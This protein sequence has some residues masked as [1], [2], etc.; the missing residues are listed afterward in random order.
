MKDEDHPLASLTRFH[1]S[2][3][4]PHPSPY[5]TREFLNAKMPSEL[6]IQIQASSSH[7]PRP[8]EFSLPTSL[9]PT[10]PSGAVAAAL[11]GTTYSTATNTIRFSLGEG[12]YSSTSGWA[13]S[14]VPS[15]SE[16]F[17]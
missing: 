9:D 16:K 8:S 13:G 10:K 2:S 15:M 17:T 1:P 12:A 11:K 7:R 4:I 3:R 6:F 14:N 5:G